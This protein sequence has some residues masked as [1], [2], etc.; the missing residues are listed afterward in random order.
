M[1]GNTCGYHDHPVSF[2][3]CRMHLSLGGKAAALFQVTDSSKTAM[4]MRQ[5]RSCHWTPVSLSNPFTQTLLHG[6]PK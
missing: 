1:R 6:T 5:L 3:H 2:V 4:Q